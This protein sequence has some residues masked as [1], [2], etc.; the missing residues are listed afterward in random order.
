ML[1]LVS[2]N[3]IKYIYNKYN[4]LIEKYWVTIIIVIQKE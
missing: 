4:I 3:D 1:S 2:D